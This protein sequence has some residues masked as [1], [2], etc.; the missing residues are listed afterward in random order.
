MGIVAVLLASVA[1]YAWGAV[2]YMVMAGP[3]MQ[4]NGLTEETIDRKNPTPYVVSF[5][6]TVLVA[7]MTRHIL[8]SGGIEGAGASLVTG[9]GLGAF[10]AAPWVVTNYAFA[11]RTRVLMLIDATYAIVGCGIIGLVLGLF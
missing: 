9:L 1:S 3:W 11:G 8:V 2:W 6:A 4:A 7:G 10:I 5:I